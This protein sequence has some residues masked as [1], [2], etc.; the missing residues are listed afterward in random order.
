MQLRI[1]AGRWRGWSVGKGDRS[2]VP[3]SRR[4]IPHSYESRAG[5]GRCEYSSVQF[6]EGCVSIRGQCGERP[7]ASGAERSTLRERVRG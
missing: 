2:H 6:A 1:P 7:I 3:I 5:R 4:L